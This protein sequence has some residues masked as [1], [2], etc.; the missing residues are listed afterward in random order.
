[1][2]TNEL[3]KEFIFYRDNQGDLVKKYEGKFV[4]IRDQQVQGAYNSEIEA[5]EEAQKKYELGTFLIQLVKS[6]EEG[7]SQTFYSRMTV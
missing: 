1:M 7:Y 3:K 6:G 2:D 5:Y 4:V